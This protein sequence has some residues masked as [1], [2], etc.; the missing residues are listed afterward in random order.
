IIGHIMSHILLSVIF[1]IFITPIAIFYKILNK[2]FFRFNNNY[3]TYWVKR[4]SI[5]FTI[6]NYKR[7]Y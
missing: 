7:Q 3:D 5:D 6:E 4:K 1:I 2:Q